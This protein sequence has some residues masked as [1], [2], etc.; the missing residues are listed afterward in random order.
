VPVYEPA[1]QSVSR[2]VLVVDGN[3]C[4]DAT[5]H[6]LSTEGVG[7]IL[8]HR[9]EP[10]IMLGVEM[11]RSSRLFRCQRTLRVWQTTEQADGTY[12]TECQFTSPIAYDQLQTLVS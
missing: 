7:F 12:L 4:W 6:T 3:D 2:R 1:H 9:L 10:G 11:T 8:R 5:L